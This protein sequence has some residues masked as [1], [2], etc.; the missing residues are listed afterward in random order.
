M[1]ARNRLGDANTD[2]GYY[3]WWMNLLSTANTKTSN[4]FWT[5]SKVAVLC[6]PTSPFSTLVIF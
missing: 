5:N 1:T 4:T 3:R 6:I 2:S